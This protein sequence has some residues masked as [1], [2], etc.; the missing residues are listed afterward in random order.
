M[1]WR[2]RGG[3]IHYASV[4]QQRCLRHWALWFEARRA[5]RPMRIA[6]SR[7]GSLRVKRV[8]L[9]TW[10]VA[11]DRR[12]VA[13]L[14][15]CAAARL[16]ADVA[17]ERAFASWTLLRLR[18][19]RRLTLD[20]RAYLFMGV[21]LLTKVY[22]GWHGLAVQR[23]QLGSLMPHAWRR[24]EALRL[25]ASFSCWASFSASTSAAIATAAVRRSLVVA[26]GSRAA[27]R[28]L[29]MYAKARSR[30]LH[31]LR[32]AAAATRSCAVARPAVEG[33]GPRFSDCSRPP[34]TWVPAVGRAA[35]P[36]CGVRAS[37]HAAGRLDA[38]ASRARREGMEGCSRRHGQTPCYF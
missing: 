11:A 4:L 15:R 21:R 26:A 38:R 33:G 29:F 18:R 19:A 1:L 17:I 24:I 32:A 22:G 25:S 3:M 8:A 20:R 37:P 6:L 23:K 30:K 13:V 5:K 9:S 28:A 2:A 10:V 31:A 36:P 27:A 16:A 35:R 7:R 14:K 12:A 34:A